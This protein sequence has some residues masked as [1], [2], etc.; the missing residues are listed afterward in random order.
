MKLAHSTSLVALIAASVLLAGPVTAQSIGTA[1][2]VNPDAAGT[3]PGGSTKTLHVGGNVVHRERIT[4][5]AKGSVQ[6]VFVDRTTLNVG[7]N[8]QLVIDEFV[9]DPNANTGRMAATLT[10]GVM[11]FV[12]GQTS[13]TGGATI[14]TPATTL[15]VRGGV[16]TISHDATAGT[17]VVNHFG[18]I[19]VQTPQGTEVIRRPGFGVTVAN[20]NAAPAAPVRAARS[21]IDNSNTQLT[22]RGS[23]TGGRRETPTDQGASKAVGQANAPVAPTLVQGQQQN[24]A[25]AAQV[26]TQPNTMQQEVPL[27]QVTQ[28]AATGSQESVTA[29]L[30]TATT[31]TT[32]P[33]VTEP[34]VTPPVVTP[35]P[36]VL[37]PKRWY[38]LASTNGSPGFLPAGLLAAGSMFTPSASVGYGVGGA[39]P[40]GSPNTTSRVLAA[41][42]SINGAG[43]AQNSAIYV[44]TA[45]LFPETAGSIPGG[46]FEATSRRGSNISMGRASGAVTP[47]PNGLTFDS[48]YTPTSINYDSLNTANGVRVS[49]GNNDPFYY[50][51]GGTPGTSFTYS[52][53]TAQVPNSATLGANRPEQGMGGFMAGLMRTFSNTLNTAAGPTFLV[54]GDLSVDLSSSSRFGVTSSMFR[55]SSSTGLATQDDYRGG[56]Q[57]WGYQGTGTRSR[58]AYVDFDNFGARDSELS[59]GGSMSQTLITNAQTVATTKNEHS[60][61]VSS[62]AVNAAAAFPNVAFCACEYTRW[63]FWSLDTQRTGT[64]STGGIDTSVQDVVH[65]G[66]WVAGN[67]PTNV[68][69]PTTGVATY[70][71]HVIGSFKSGFNEY[72]AAGNLSHTI[73]FGTSTGTATVSNLDGRNYTLS[74]SL[75]A[76]TGADNRV[77]IAA[78]GL[79]NGLPAT[80]QSPGQVIATT[81]MQMFGHFMKGAASPVAEMGGQFSVSGL[82]YIGTGTFAARK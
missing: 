82:N 70:T 60:L 10:K 52:G 55:F 76:A 56:I 73:N 62:G 7:P 42:I 51:G 30:P 58:S 14:K 61:F 24:T 20:T 74:S 28:V 17:R 75:V 50:P 4:T 48:N 29:T 36:V 38:T 2:A 69:V 81:Q 43:T 64:T 63:G 80:V 6:L 37:P 77:Y 5:T 19:S 31:T 21:E 39:N 12:G 44:L 46:G 32:T 59:A 49:G 18:R 68:E 8:S 57:Y 40:D 54:A 41:G 15:G 13:H 9:Y 16:A 3:P 66:T 67:K 45:D 71:G 35:P 47:T 27:Q 23:Q 25:Q 26:T 34:V 53:S 79:A 72:L 1:G 65:M 33:V 78:S 11:R 22:S